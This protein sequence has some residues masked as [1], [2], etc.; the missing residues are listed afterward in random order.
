MDSEPQ[1]QKQKSHARRYSRRIQIEEKRTAENLIFGTL[2][3]R[4][5]TIAKTPKLKPS[6][7]AEPSQAKEKTSR[8]KNKSLLPPHQA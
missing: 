5:N 2:L 4:L 3:I 1:D 6:T 7:V 8:E